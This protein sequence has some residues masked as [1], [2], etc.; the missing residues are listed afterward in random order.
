MSREITHIM[1]CSQCDALQRVT[2]PEGDG[3]AVCYRCGNDVLRG[4][5]LHADALTGIVLFLIGNFSP[6]LI[7][8]VQGSRI[9]SSFFNSTMALWNQDLEMIAATVFLTSVAMP[10][11]I[12]LSTLFLT[13]CI[14]LRQRKILKRLPKAFEPVLRLAQAVREWSM[15]EV[16]MLGAVVSYVKIT[17]QNRA[18]IYAGPAL[19][20]SALLVVVLMIL[21]TWFHPRDLW[22]EIVTRE[23]LAA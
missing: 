14:S 21:T 13:G 11:L 18:Q 19:W 20:S 23:E 6:L 1:A 3:T 2:P 22:D 9:L 16:F 5:N 7:L 8:D 4:R 12:L 17:S 15:V 10:G